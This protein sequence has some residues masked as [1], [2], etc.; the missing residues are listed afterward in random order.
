MRIKLFVV[1]NLVFLFYKS[2]ACAIFLREIIIFTAIFH[3]VCISHYKSIKQ[4]DD[5]FYK[6]IIEAK[7]KQ[8]CNLPAHYTTE[9]K[10]VWRYYN[11]NYYRIKDAFN[12]VTY[13]TEWRI[14]STAVAQVVTIIAVEVWRQ[15]HFVM[16]WWHMDVVSMSY[17]HRMFT[18][19]STN[20]AV[21]KI[22]SSVG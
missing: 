6:K 11:K 13:E 2:M 9:D 17:W 21:L 7:S 8:N 14:A 20:K 19:N 10:R 4:I 12:I 18:E 15:Y 1:S 3:I 22:N 5:N 16:I